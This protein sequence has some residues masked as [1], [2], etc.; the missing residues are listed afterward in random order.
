MDQEDNVYNNN[1]LEGPRIEVGPNGISNKS[2]FESSNSGGFSKVLILLVILMIFGGAMF[3]GAMAFI[4]NMQEDFL[5]EANY[6]SD[7]SETSTETVN[8][9][10]Y[11]YVGE[12]GIKIKKPESWQ[13]DVAYNYN[14]NIGR[15]APDALTITTSETYPHGALIEQKGS[16]YTCADII[17]PF[18]A[19]FEFNDRAYTIN[20][21][22]K[23]H[24]ED[25]YELFVSNYEFLI[26]PENYSKI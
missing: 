12:W 18:D 4:R 11:I 7:T 23:A 24:G 14:F 21:N 17:H 3:G 15:Q 9:E 1:N 25:S 13:D 8:S 20:Y 22:W 19:C 26:N 6:A 16:M 10:D 5:N 2:S